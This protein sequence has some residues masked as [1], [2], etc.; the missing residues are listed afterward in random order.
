MH[1]YTLDPWGAVTLGLCLILIQWCAEQSLLSSLLLAL[2]PSLQNPYI[3]FHIMLIVV[4]HV[5]LGFFVVVFVLGGI[6][7][8]IQD[9]LLIL[10][11]EITHSG[12]GTKD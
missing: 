2:W 9:L 12:W 10:H 6:P 1:I 7:S 8:D 5:G 11:S 3:L 4:L